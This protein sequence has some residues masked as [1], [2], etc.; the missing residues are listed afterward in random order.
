[1]AGGGASGVHGAPVDGD[2]DG[3]RGSS[4][5]RLNKLGGGSDLNIWGCS[6]S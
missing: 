3:R 2:E 1:V 6:S 4:T 5:S